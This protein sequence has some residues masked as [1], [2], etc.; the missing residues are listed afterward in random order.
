MHSGTKVDHGSVQGHTHRKTNIKQSRDKQRTTD[1][2][3][4][5]KAVME[6]RPGDGK[7]D[8]SG[9]G[10]GGQSGRGKG[11]SGASACHDSHVG[12][13]AR[14]RTLTAVQRPA[15]LRSPASA[16][17]RPWELT[18][19]HTYTHFHVRNYLLPHYACVQRRHAHVH[20]SLLIYTHAYKSSCTQMHAYT[21]VLV[22]AHIH[23]SLLMHTYMYAYVC[24][25]ILCRDIL[26]YTEG[27]GN[28]QTEAEII[29]QFEL[30]L[31]LFHRHAVF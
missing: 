15:A 5:R 11:G 3:Q 2:P 12:H 19:T 28:T 13:E 17:T 6:I 29:V 1:H 26:V 20:A 22:R 31:S 14:Q 30:L 23:V 4:R 9:A 27:Y 21:P 16:S 10:K 18:Y 24:A 25:H 7:G 8:E